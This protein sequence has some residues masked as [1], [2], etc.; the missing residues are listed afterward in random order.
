MSEVNE[1]L[2]TG[3]PKCSTGTNEP[4]S[5]LVHIN[6]GTLLCVDLLLINL[7]CHI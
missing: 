3:E 5:E 2:N 4:F 1:T 7:F 6:H